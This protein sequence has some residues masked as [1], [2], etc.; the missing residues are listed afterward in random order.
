MPWEQNSNGK[1]YFHNNNGS[2]RNVEAG[3]RAR[4]GAE[5]THDINSALDHRP[6]ADFPSTPEWL[7]LMKEEN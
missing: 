3:V 5:Y 2:G 1:W 7:K 4:R 6:P